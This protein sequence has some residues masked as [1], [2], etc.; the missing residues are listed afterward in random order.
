ME[1]YGVTNK[2]DGEITE[3]F[4]G[5]ILL[6]STRSSYSESKRLAELLVLSYGIKTITLRPTQ[7]IG[8]G[9]N[10]NNFRVFAEFTRQ[11]LLNY[12]IVMKTEG[13]TVRSYIYSRDN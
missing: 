9:V 13:K 8:A 7:I 10:F 1:V 2:D 12:K 6:N 5:K 11:A 3:D 4:C